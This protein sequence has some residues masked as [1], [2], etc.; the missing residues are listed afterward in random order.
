MELLSVV[1]V[2][3]TCLEGS[4]LKTHALISEWRRFLIGP[5][6]R[7]RNFMLGNWENHKTWVC[8]QMLSLT[9]MCKEKW[10]CSK[11]PI[12]LLG[13]L[14]EK[15]ILKKVKSLFQN[16]IFISIIFFQH[17]SFCATFFT[18]WLARYNNLWHSSTFFFIVFE[19]FAESN[20]I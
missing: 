6:A 16:Q 12:V 13:L 15:F 7:A 17:S 8:V 4:L 1:E 14:Q 9:T 20:I 10:N 19:D 18:A 3:K 2:N 11:V 5:L